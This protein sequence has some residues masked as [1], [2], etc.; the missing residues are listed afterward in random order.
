MAIKVICDLCGLDEVQNN[1]RM[2]RIREFVWN[3]RPKWYLVETY[4]I[5][6]CDEC[7]NEIKQRHNK[8]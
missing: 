4:Q 6:I 2:C 5:Q 1:L 3:E 8:K 7:I